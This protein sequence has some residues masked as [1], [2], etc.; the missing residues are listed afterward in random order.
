[1]TSLISVLLSSAP[2]K[3]D[4]AQTPAWL[5]LLGAAFSFGP[6]VF[7]AENDIDAVFKSIFSYLEAT[8]ATIRTGASRAVTALVSKC[9]T[10]PMVE[11]A[12]TER[13]QKKPN[14]PV[15]KILA[16]V[17]MSLETLSYAR[18]MPQMLAVL[19]SLL[20][21]LRSRPKVSAGF[22]LTA[23]ELLLLDIVQKIG[24]LRVKNSFEHKEAA[25]EVL[26]AAMSVLGPEVILR[27]LPLGLIPED[28]WAHLLHLRSIY[29]NVVLVPLGVSLMHT[30][31]HYW[32]F[33]TLRR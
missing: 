33:R 15:G 24:E 17:R 10:L 1:M 21:A 5:D 13:S 27:V 6:I 18:A 8:D 3:S 7:P 30:C 32:P 25:D 9:I 22:P 19:A 14:S 2:S 12:V 11:A 29:L 28:R 26:K 16:H 4:A 23:A 31:F 20:L